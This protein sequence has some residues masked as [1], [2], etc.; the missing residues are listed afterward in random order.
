MTKQYLN[1]NNN[2]V[3]GESNTF[4]IDVQLKWGNFDSHDIHKYTKVKFIEYTSDNMSVYPSPFG[5]IICFDLAYNTYSC[6]GNYFKGLKE[7]LV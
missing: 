1:E 6:Y 5:I 3:V 2:Q 4:W 7:I